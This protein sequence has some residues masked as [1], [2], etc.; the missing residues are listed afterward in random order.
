MRTRKQLHILASDRGAGKALTA[1]RRALQLFLDSA[2]KIPKPPPQEGARLRETVL[3]TR[4]GVGKDFT[5]DEANVLQHVQG[6]G[7]RRRADAR[8]GRLNVGE[9]HRPAS[10]HEIQHG[11]RMLPCYGTNELLD[12][13]IAGSRRRRLGLT[14]SAATNGEWLRL[15]TPIY[16][17]TL[18]F[19][20]C[21][22]AADHHRQSYTPRPRTAGSRPPKLS[23]QIEHDRLQ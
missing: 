7:K 12:G 1:R 18:Q 4:R 5:A 19:T 14:A 6:L 23:R 17:H 8:Q 21:K 15:G 20:M 3:N 22:G 13:A 2:E 16:P 10:T 11:E 9:S